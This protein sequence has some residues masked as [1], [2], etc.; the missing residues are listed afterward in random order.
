MQPALNMSDAGGITDVG[1]GKV[2]NS[3]ARMANIFKPCT[4]TYTG[5]AG[6]CENVPWSTPVRAPPPAPVSSV[7]VK[8]VE[9]SSLQNQQSES[10]KFG[11]TQFTQVDPLKLE[12]S[13]R[14]LNQHTVSLA[15]YA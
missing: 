15:H 2:F 8:T 7:C 9:E 1:A 10:T 12:E 4:V 13:I 3:I 6:V 14:L 11:L 5:F